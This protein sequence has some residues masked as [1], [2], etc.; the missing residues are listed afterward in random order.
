MTNSDKS[1][2]PNNSVLNSNNTQVSGDFS[3]PYSLIEWVKNLKIVS[4]DTVAYINSYNQYLNDWFDQVSTDKIDKVLFVRLQYIN[5]LKEISLKYT[6]PD[7][8]RFLS[9]INL[10]DNQSLDIAI[11]FFTKKIKK[12]CQYYAKNRDK[13][14]G[15]VLQANL[16]GSDYGIE[17]LIKKAIVSIL[18]QNDFEPTGYILPPLSSVLP[19]LHINIDDSYD[20]QENYFDI[21]PDS[22]SAKYNVQDPERKEFFGLDS[23]SV[24]N[25]STYNLNAAIIDAIKSYPFFLEELGFTSFTVNFPLS[26]INYSYLDS[27]D[28][29]NYENDA[30]ATNTNVYNYKKLYQQ[31]MGNKMLAISGGSVNTLLSSY[32]LIPNFPHQN[33][34]NRRFPTIA[35][36]PE[37]TQTKREKYLGDFFTK[38]N[39]GILFW[40]TYKKTYTITPS[41][42]GDEVLLIPDPEVG[43]NASGLSLTDHS[44]SSVNYLVDLQWN[45]YDWSND[46]AF[47]GIYSDP[48]IHKFYSY[49]SKTEISQDSDE[50]ISRITD[51]QDF[52]NDR[53]LW[54]NKDVFDFSGDDFYPLDERTQYLLYNKGILTKYKTDI[55]GNHYGLFKISLKNDYTQSGTTTAYPSATN[56]F[57]T[58][59]TPLCSLYNKQNFQ[60]GTP[61]VRLYDDTQILPLSSALSAI[62]V[63]YPNIVKDELEN[64]IVDLDVIHNTII[65]ETKNYIV[66]EKI[67]FDYKTGK[68]DVVY[69]TNS[70]FK[71]YNT[72]PQ[73]E[74]YSNFWYDADSRNL[75]VNFL[76]LFSENSSTSKKI[77]YPKI[78]ISNIDKIDFR[79]LYPLEENMQT[80]SSFV[81]NLSS[82]NFNLNYNDKSVMNV[83]HEAQILGILVKGYNNTGI[84]VLQNY[85][86]TKSFDSINLQQHLVFKPCGF[87]YDRN[88]NDVIKNQSVRH[89]GLVS[90][91]VANQKSFNSLVCSLSSQDVYNYYYASAEDLTISNTISSFIVCDETITNIFNI[92]AGNVALN[93]RDVYGTLVYDFSGSNEYYFT[94]IND[95]LTAQDGIDIFSITYVAS[96]QHV[97]FLEPR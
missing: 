30:N 46:Y 29:Q 61:F 56:T 70:Y 2:I 39:L 50:G 60:I 66:F 5:L 83:S 62:F 78:Y 97:I 27:R 12:I 63:K 57:T 36:I 51:Y 90:Q 85:K 53:I 72:N 3:K 81:F 13:L 48:K 55:F 23:T 87:I 54:K 59:V 17:T 1:Y 33:I 24:D 74:N 93:L 11:P 88:Y 10:N 92:T 6:T 22:D 7:E 95:T 52:W 4:T 45:R 75:F 19:D 80:L 26:T 68:F 31:N 91:I 32:V 25:K 73:I 84:P 69:T 28:F 79:K 21:E 76:T 34:L 96:G 9:N 58:N 40:N 71:K 65:L 20:V 94:S 67:N 15:G 43:A 49:T 44:L 37:I 42:S 89:I 41:L 35:N 14:T 18:E 16:R 82:E 47:G 86:F 77:T 64:S 38:D 8:K